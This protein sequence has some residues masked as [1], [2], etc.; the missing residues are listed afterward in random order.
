MD[1][2]VGVVV[3]AFRPDPERLE[4]Y[5]EALTDR[6]DPAAVRVEL[7]DPA[8][9]MRERLDGLPATVAVSHH[10]R[11]KGAAVTAGFEALAVGPAEVLAFADADGSTPADSVA[12]VVDAVETGAADL[13][14]GSRRHPDADVVSHQT[15]A[16]RHLGDA[17]A[18]LAR[19]ALAVELT[20]YQ[21]GAKAISVPAWTG[22]RDHLYEPGF[23]WDIELVAVAGALGLDVVERPV[24]WEDQPGSTVDPV[25]TPARMARGLASA[26][27]RARLIRRDPLHT[28]LDAP[29]DD[30]P[31]LVDRAHAPADD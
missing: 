23:A 31:A 6:L 1:S 12:A 15:V 2:P 4:A 14:V 11:G 22:V 25:R 19:Q 13:S 5:V 28:L 30:R 20:D 24:V 21:C 17:F 10:R 8:P 16:R 26:R 29:R 3:P 7:D 27:H 18:W 9:G